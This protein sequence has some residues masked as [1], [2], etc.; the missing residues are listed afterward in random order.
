[1]KIPKVLKWPFVKARRLLVTAAIVGLFAAA[2]IF[3]LKRGSSESEAKSYYEHGLM[4]SEQHDYAKAAIELRNALRL[5]NDMLPAWRRLAQVEEKTQQWERVIQS[6]QSIVS[7]DPRDIDTR[8]KLAKLLALGG[9][10]NQALELT[11][12]INEEDRQNAKILGVKAGILYKLNDK[13]AAVREANKALSIEPGN[14]DAIV[15]LATDRMA[16]GDMEGALRILSNDAGRENSDLGVQL[17]ELKIYEQSGATEKFESLLT[18]LIKRYPDELGFRKKLTKFYID[19]HRENDAEGVMRA[20]VAANPTNSEAEL[21]LVRYLYAIKGPN[22]AKQE[23]VSRVNA[24][25]D[26]FPYQVALAD[27]EVAQGNIT[28]AE[29]IIQGLVEH[30][31]SPEQVSAA[32]AKLAEMDLKRN[33]I[34]AAE[35]LVSKILGKDSGNVNGL[36]LQGS[37]RIARGQPKAAIADLQRALSEK[38]RSTEL[39]LLLAVAYE[40]SGSI[41]LAEKQYADAVRTSENNPSVGLSYASFLLRRGNVDRAK[42]FLTELSRRS[43]RNLEVLSALAQAELTHQDWAG[44]K[45][46][47]EAIRKAGDPRGVADQVLGAALIGEHKYDESIAAFQN[48]ASA[49]PLAVQPMASLVTALVRAHKSDRALAFLK[50][51]IKANPD[52]ADAYVLMG[53]VQ[54]AD[55]ARDQAIESFKS[56]IERQPKSIVGYQAVANFYVGDKKYSQALAVIRSGLQVQPDSIILQLALANALELARQYDAAITEY[57]N[58]L[59]KQPGSMIVANNL[60]SL[61]ADRRSDKASLDR[62]QSLAEML[63]G[64]Q[65]PQFKD[66]LGWI[67]YRKGDFR[68]AVLLLEKAAAALPNVAVVHYHLAMSYMALQ[69][70]AKASEQFKVTLSLAPDS[71]LQQK[72]H[73]AL[74]SLPTNTKVN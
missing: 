22:A 14:A 43:P 45:A 61:L 20:T 48:A 33:K 8:V 55:G 56:A 26:V 46:T 38:P 17:L 54:L 30:A 68:A 50:S 12:S 31:D 67:M 34:D 32:Q 21:D 73:E 3:V 1:M 24:G 70:P 64:S 7:L 59:S 10:V 23:L 53:S 71:E 9:R 35:E 44:A 15:V 18:E 6:L 39:M 16:Q 63:Q 42:E 65:V 57:E 37:I 58:M 41:G 5:K 27:F 69:Q 4:L 51:T 2:V 29:Q 62:A 25:G 28:G 52:N 66:T 74:N 19:Q 13:L 60:A 49:S 40:R 36:K 47:S 72:T 11:N